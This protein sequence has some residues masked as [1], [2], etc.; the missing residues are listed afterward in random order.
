MTKQLK[1]ALWNLK[2][3]D[4]SQPVGSYFVEVIGIIDQPI[5]GIG[6][7]MDV[8]VYM[9]LILKRLREQKR[10][11]SSGQDG[12]REGLYVSEDVNKSVFTFVTPRG[13][14][15]L[16][17]TPQTQYKKEEYLLE[18]LDVAKIT[19][20]KLNRLEELLGPMLEVE[21][22]GRSTAESVDELR[23]QLG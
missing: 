6:G 16:T 7:F 23:K 22:L 19:I 11:R 20:E 2:S 15:R 4:K 9:D 10:T 12:S 8:E 18:V 14:V 5:T 21:V 13:K 3:V 1:G 17:F